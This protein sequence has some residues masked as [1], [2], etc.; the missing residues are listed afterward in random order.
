MAFERYAL[1]VTK[2][3]RVISAD[4]GHGRNRRA[5]RKHLL[6][7]FSPPGKQH[8][9]DDFLVMHTNAS[10][11]SGKYHLRDEPFYGNLPH[12]FPPPPPTSFC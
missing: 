3:P 9:G 10:H 7:T 8:D 1:P 4:F 5:T 2:T 6:K 12:F 11:S